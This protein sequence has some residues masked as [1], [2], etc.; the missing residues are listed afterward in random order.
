MGVENNSLI[1]KIT[2]CHT[3]ALSEN[4]E[5]YRSKNMLSQLVCL[6]NTDSGKRSFTLH[7]DSFL[8]LHQQ[9]PAP[10]F[11]PSLSSLNSNT[12]MHGSER[13][14]RGVDIKKIKSC[15]GQMLA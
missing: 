1:M 13:G 5:K 2:R 10:H 11:L 15:E 4:C 7:E 14:G 6:F 12:V 8:N 3:C 9:D